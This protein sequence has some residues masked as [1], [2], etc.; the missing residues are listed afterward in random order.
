MRGNSTSRKPYVIVFNLSEAAPDIFLPLA[1]IVKTD[2]HGSPT[3][4]Q[5]RALPDTLGAFHLELTPKLKRLFELVEELDLET[6]EKHFCPPRRKVKPI[7]TL[8]E[9]QEVKKA[10]LIHVHRRLDE[11]LRICVEQGYGISWEAERKSLVGDLLLEP[12]K[13]DLKPE[14]FFERTREGVTYQL[15]LREGRQ[16][17]PIHTKDVTVLTNVPA[18]IIVG[19]RLYQV[20]HINGFMVKP[21]RQKDTIR[22]PRSSVRTYFKQFIFKVASKTDI[23]AE[24]FDVMQYNKL[25][26]CELEPVRL[27]F[28]EAWGL[29][30]HMVY[31]LARFNWSDKKEQT[32]SLKMGEGQDEISIL[33]VRRDK[34]AEGIYMAQVRKLGLVNQDGSYF[35][36]PKDAEAED[37]LFWLADRR[38]ELEELGFRLRSPQWEGKP[39]ALYRPSLQLNASQNNDWFDIHGEIELGPHRI[40]F[41]EIARYIKAENRYFPLPDGT[42]FLIPEE[43]MHRYREVVAFGRFKGDKLHL[44]KSQFTLLSELDI[45]AA[46]MVDVAEVEAD[47]ALPDGLRADL[48][49]YQ[50]DGV[51][52]MVQHYQND[53]GACLADDMGLGK[54]LQTIAVLLYAKERRATAAPA[55]VNS[56]AQ[57]DL[58]SAPA[59]DM[60]FLKPLNALII[61]PASLIFNWMKEIDKF[62]PGLS[63]YNHTGPKRHTDVRLLSRFDVII[64]TYQT[65]LR[66]IELLERMEFEYVV[67][68]ESQQ[69]KNRESKVFQ[70]VNK[71]NAGHKISLSGTPIENSLA[72]L[73]SQMQFINPNLLGSFRFFKKEF[74]TPIEKQQD[75][76]K[77]D[78]LRT[79][80]Q[81]YLLRRTKEEVARDLPPLIT[82][83]FYSDMEA[84]QKK[85][86]E[87]EKSAA[88]NYLLENFL[89]NDPQYRIMVLQ[90]LT[91]LRQMAN[92]PALVLEDYGKE[93][94]KF[95]DVLEHW[96]VIRRAGHKALFFSSFVKYLELFRTQFQSEKQQFSWLTGS[97]KPEERQREIQKFE[98]DPDIES[99]LISIKSGGTGLNLTAADYVFILDPWWNPTVEQQAIARAHRIG[100]DKQVIAVKFITRDS[101]EE[102]ILALQDKKAQL[103]EDIIGNSGKMDFSREDLEYLLL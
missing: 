17:W 9:D 88:R 91:K 22:I 76:L 75:D 54:T 55:Q 74:I 24:G 14:L 51:R 18:W 48:R 47:F 52:W 3:Y 29:S 26:A 46:A 12:S 100:Q 19:Y 23:I 8:L 57:L 87:K 37:L 38:K 71:L 58:F 62:A 84:E 30:V 4:I 25:E 73:W 6:I 70:A 85:I 95:K 94:G 65:A 31:Q 82:K 39:I 93:S 56:G 83:I 50:L 27:L 11:I 16:V 97:L 13:Q 43:W 45:E 44:A 21:F 64:T 66:D 34:V 53:L 41:L 103:A 40:P 61:L 78:R 59:P 35:Q 89:P 33:Q 92:H 36:L 99:F 79:M 98:S 5:Q 67:L 7:G 77:K 72:D 15:R 86:Y 102:K 96:S 63:V 42:F 49:P 20:E 60:D 90:S 68:D 69:I 1:F 81:P 80:V 10:V 2:R 32:T 28:S 101:I